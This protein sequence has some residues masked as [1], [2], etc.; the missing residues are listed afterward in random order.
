MAFVDLF[1]K[2]NQNRAS[3][4]AKSCTELFIYIFFY[5]IKDLQ[6]HLAST[7]ITTFFIKGDKLLSKK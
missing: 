6:K 1:Y 2:V 3:Y 4:I 5:E 7:T